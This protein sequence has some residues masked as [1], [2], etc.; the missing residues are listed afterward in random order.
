VVSFLGPVPEEEKAGRYRRA[1][2]NVLMSE[3]EGWGLT[4]LE[5]ALESTPSVVAFAPGLWDAVTHLG[6]GLW[7]PY[8]H[9]PTLADGLRYL[10]DHPVMVERLGE[11]ARARAN[12]RNWGQAALELEAALLD[13][14]EACRAKTAVFP[15]ASNESTS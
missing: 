8:H 1:W 12:G 14:A 7:I 4:V 11:A 2:A 6:T 9:L 15:A 10:L 3:K 5:A 13:H